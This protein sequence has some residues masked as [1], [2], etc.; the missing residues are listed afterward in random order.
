MT[1]MNIKPMLCLQHRPTDLVTSTATT[2]SAAPALLPECPSLRRRCH[3]LF[4]LPPERPSQHHH[5]RRLLRL[6]RRSVRPY[7]VGAI[8]CSGSHRNARPSAAVTI[9]C[10]G[11]SVEASVLT[12]S[13]PSTVLAPA[14]TSLIAPPTPLAAPAPAPERLA[15]P[16]HHHWLRRRSRWSVCH[17]TVNAIG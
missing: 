13:V 1:Q 9:G 14:G 7:G 15:L 16:R 5:H 3:R 8:S 4:W 6:C 17:Y 11:S 12:A 10:S 2:S